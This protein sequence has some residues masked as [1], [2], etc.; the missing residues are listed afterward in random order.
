MPQSTVRRVRELAGFSPKTHPSPTKPTPAALKA[1]P[2]TAKIAQSDAKSA[3]DVDELFQAH[4]TGD[5]AVADKL[6]YPTKPAPGYKSTG[7]HRPKPK[8]SVE[9]IDALLSSH[10][11]EAMRDARLDQRVKEVWQQNGIEEKTYEDQKDAY[12][13]VLRKTCAIVEASGSANMDVTVYADQVRLASAGSYPCCDPNKQNNEKQKHAVKLKQIQCSDPLCEV[14]SFHI[15]CLW[16]VE[17]KNYK[18]FQ[19]LPKKDVMQGRWMCDHCVAIRAQG[20][21]PELEL[22]VGELKRADA[23]LAHD[24]VAAISAAVVHEAVQIPDQ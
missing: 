19:N 5:S 2:Q 20:G 11:Q 4:R 17:L 6:R 9:E 3:P 16:D 15:G 14:G 22:I 24:P 12:E 18:A 13:A 10:K 8:L 23:G 7:S 21:F 1:A